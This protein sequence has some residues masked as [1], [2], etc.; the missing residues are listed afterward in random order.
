MAL[1]LQQLAAA[2]A[3]ASPPAPLYVLCRRGNDSQRVVARL[4]Q[5]GVGNAVDVAG[6]LER[7]GLEVD[8][9]LPRL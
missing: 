7:W 3:A 8:A 5:Q 9:S 1:Q 2:A 6:G 4:R